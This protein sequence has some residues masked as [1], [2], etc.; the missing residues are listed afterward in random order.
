MTTHQ[1]T[2]TSS[3]VTAKTKAPFL[4]K[5]E[6]FGKTPLIIFVP[7]IE[8]HQGMPP[9]ARATVIFGFEKSEYPQTGSV[10]I[11]NNFK[12]LTRIEF[13]DIPHSSPFAPLPL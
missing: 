6:K 8:R 5:V 10:M 7:K 12:C 2:M 3:R 1:I 11:V 9:F 4:A 13:S